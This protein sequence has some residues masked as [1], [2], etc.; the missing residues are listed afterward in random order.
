MTIVKYAVTDD[1]NNTYNFSINAII[2]TG[3][4]ISLIREDYA[5][6]NIR[7]P[8]PLNMTSYYGINKSKINILGI[9]EI[10]CIVDNISIKVTFYVVPIETITFAAIFGRDYILSHGY[11]ILLI[12]KEKIKNKTPDKNEQIEDLDIF[13]KNCVSETITAIKKLNINLKLEHSDKVRIER[14][15]ANEYLEMQS[16]RPSGDQPTTAS[17]S[18]TELIISLKHDQPISYRP[19][20][21]SYSDKQK[22]QEILDDLLKKNIIRPS[23]SPYASPIVL[24]HKK[25]GEL[26]LCIDYCELNK[27]TIKDN[28]STPLIE[29]QSAT[30]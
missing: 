24:V 11:G 21:L 30:R 6:Y 4:P 2:D 18:D 1:C 28:F 27:I 13:Q 29:D 3:S 17:P 22:L 10:D 19:R 26:R 5:P 8:I 15:F 16:P 14:L 9:S 12:D 20:R 25:N 23:N 7:R